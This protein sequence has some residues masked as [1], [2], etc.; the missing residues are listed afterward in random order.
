VE[1]LLTPKKPKKKMKNAMDEYRKRQ[2]NFRGA[3][4]SGAAQQSRHFVD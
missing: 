2:R 4:V 1:A 3:R